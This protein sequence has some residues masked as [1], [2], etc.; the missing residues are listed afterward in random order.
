MADREEKKD[1]II[2][3]TVLGFCIVVIGWLIYKHTGQ[4]TGQITPLYWAGAVLPVLL[5]VSRQVFNLK[6]PDK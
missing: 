1:E 3:Y 5:Q 6:K 4:D 2:Q